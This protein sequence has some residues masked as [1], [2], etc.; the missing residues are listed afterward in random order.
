MWRLKH[1]CCWLFWLECVCCWTCYVQKCK[2]PFYL[3]I[4]D[5]F[6]KLRRGDLERTLRLEMILCGWRDINIKDSTD[7]K[8]QAT[9]LCWILPFLVVEGRSFNWFPILCFTLRGVTI[10]CFA[11]QVKKI[12]TVEQSVWLPRPSPSCCRLPSV[13]S[14]RFP[15]SD[16]GTLTADW[17]QAWLELRP[18]TLR[19]TSFF[20]VCV[21]V[22]DIF[23]LSI[24]PYVDID[25]KLWD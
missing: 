6:L 3:W 2:P 20:L 1:A 21:C 15:D 4:G 8:W 19:W 13:H 23:P 14:S 5:V 10:I 7:F 16:D 22:C 25:Y 9:L 17:P 11:L 12:R 24:S 18:R